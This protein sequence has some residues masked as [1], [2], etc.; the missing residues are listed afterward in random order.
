MDKMLAENIAGRAQA[1]GAAPIV[2]VSKEVKTFQVCVDYRKLGSIPKRDS[3]Q[4]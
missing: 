1:E 2:F 3:Y 4:I